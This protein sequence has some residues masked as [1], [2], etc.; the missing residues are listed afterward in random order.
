MLGVS[1]YLHLFIV[2][3]TLGRKTS[4][5]KLKR[6]KI[7]D[8]DALRTSSTRPHVFYVHIDITL[9]LYIYIY[10]LIYYKLQKIPGL[11]K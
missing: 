7:I 10:I 2:G 1:F 9:Y 5:N 4:E 11:V 6:R 3:L 8:N